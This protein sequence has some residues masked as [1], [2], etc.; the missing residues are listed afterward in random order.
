[1]LSRRCA[2]WAVRAGKACVGSSIQV[3]WNGLIIRWSVNAFR[4]VLG[5]NVRF[6]AKVVGSSSTCIFI[7]LKMSRIILEAVLDCIIGG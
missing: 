2:A 1:M 4:L 5:L 6:G 7:G 3:F